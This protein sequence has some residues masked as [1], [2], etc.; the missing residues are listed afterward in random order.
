MSNVICYLSGVA[1]GIRIK[2]QRLKRKWSQRVLAQH[3]GVSGPF[4]SQVERGNSDIT[5][6]KLVM[7]AKAFQISVCE[8]V[9]GK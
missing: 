4:I 2:Q 6:G 3:S 9:E 8:L 7:L 5:H 1:I